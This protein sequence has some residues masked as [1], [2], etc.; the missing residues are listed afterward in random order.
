VQAL[1][2]GQQVTDVFTYTDSDNNGGSSTSTLT[3][4][5]TGSNDA[6]VAVA[7][8][9]A[10]KED[11]N[12]EAQ[13]NPVSGNLLTND[14][15]VDSGDTHA[16]SALSGGTDDGTT[17]TKVGTYGTLVIV[18]ATGAYTYTLANSQANVQALAAD[19]QVTDVFTYTNSDNHGGSSVSTLTVTVTGTNDAPV[20]VADVAALTEDA[21][22]NPVS[23]NLL[24][25]D[26]DVDTGDTH[27]VS[28]LS[29]GTDNGTTITKVGTYGTLVITKATGA[30]TY[31]LANSQANVQ[32]LAAGQQVTDV[33]TYTNP[34]N[35][36]GSSAS[37]L[38]LTVT[39]SND[40]PV[41]IADVAAVKEDTNTE[42]RPNPVTGN[43]LSNDID[44]DSN[45]T[46]TVSALS[47]GTDNGTTITKVGTYGTLVITKATGAYTYTLANSQANVQA[48]AAD[49][50][51]TDVFTYTNS[52]NH[53]GSSASTLTVTVTGTNDAPV[54][55]ADVASV[56]EDALS[57]TVTGNLL[58]N[59]TD[60][61]ST[62][63]HSVSALSGGT[64]NGTTITKVGT[65]GTLVITK[66]T[67]AYT[68]TLANGQANVQALA[69]GQQVTDVFTYTN[70]DNHGGSIAST[71]TLTVTGS[72]DAPV[73]VA[74]VAAVKEDTNTVARPN[75]VT[76]N[77]LSNDTD[78][79][80][81]DTHTVS[82]LSGGTDNGTTIT[83]VGTYGTLVITKATG[84]YTY[85]LANGQANV[86]ALADG[87]QVTDVF[88]YT[89]ADN[90]GGSGASTL[91]VTISGS[92]DA[93][94]AVADLAAVTEDALPNPV[95]GNLLANDTDVDSGDA[96]TVSA[97]SGG[98]DNGTT[99]TKVGTYGTLVI[100][101]A[102]G[103]YTYT[104]ANGQAN[105][106]A[107]ADGQQ[108][109]DVFT[110]TDSDN[111]GGSS[112]STL[113]VT[114]TGTA[115]ANHWS[116]ASSGLWGTASNW[117]NGAPT[118]NTNAVIDA[119]DDDF[120]VV[121][122]NT[123]AVANSLTINN[124]SAIVA[125]LSGGSLVLQ[126]A[127][128][129]SA[130]T[131]LLAGS[132][133]AN[134]VYVDDGIF[135]FLGGTLK[136]N[137]I[138]S[139]SHLYVEGSQNLL[140]ADAGIT[141]NGSIQVDFGSLNIASAVS[142]T[143]SFTITHE[144]TLDF[145]SSNTASVIFAEDSEGT[146]KI[147]Q[148]FDQSHSLTFGGL[149]YGVTDDTY[150]DVTN[151]TFVKNQMSWSSTYLSSTNTTTVVF[152]NGTG[153]QHFTLNLAGD[154]HSSSWNF[155]KDSAG[156]GTIFHDPPATDMAL[157]DLGA[158][159]ATLGVAT[160]AMTHTSAS[161]SADV[162]QTVSDALTILDQFAFQDDSQSNTQAQASATDTAALD[163]SAN[164]SSDDQSTAATADGSAD[165]SPAN[166]VAT[167]SQPATDN[168]TTSNTHLDTPTQTAASPAATGDTFVFAANFGNVTLTNFDPGTDVIEIDHTVFA[169][170]QALLAAAQDDGNGNSV[171]AADPH[172]TITIKN[173][174]VAQLIQHQGDFHF[175]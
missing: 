90:H 117:S 138:S 14:T 175:T 5:V 35:H 131:F 102:T 19:Q 124:P 130:G 108:V 40:A 48:L 39:G 114:V 151:F 68:Y 98:T 34:D 115:E 50:Q 66:A 9:T 143:G 144:A 92:N 46:H 71:L 122:I 82:A 172:D 11:T 31:T 157:A 167:N 21:Q 118:S 24:S 135:A 134:S 160:D 33:F 78:V 77:L 147:D 38:T 12:T 109:T 120:Y 63:T 51:V 126:G 54:A 170:F 149:V 95:S 103:A 136:T 152:G 75:P 10:V 27:S 105:V 153:G 76:G 141:N 3:V 88:T 81:T 121:G 84:A 42:A 37:T 79:D 69:A 26:T 162:A 59:D 148:A 119:D 74:D 163:T 1:A 104:L 156:T 17:L 159:A 6:P 145:D 72:N 2:D 53:G 4:T 166:N 112:A 61:D 99:I 80:S 91:T 20:A 44:V 36:G 87:Q 129:L 30:Y 174:T 60:V 67:G 43:L 168:S 85:T 16:V 97:L 116:T 137:S 173:V 132:L 110:Y 29:G 140:L 165:S 41:A 89:N 45:D 133:Q 96:H 139:G 13:P 23:G 146:L 106:Q 127:L 155:A 62:D 64:D 107:L 28:A 83:K 73:A 22:P 154:Y 18:K 150:F 94:V 101:K 169:D 7:D 49:Q 171:I 56:T 70:S 123:S 65:Y 52:D 164:S 55:V 111:H 113:T 100:T 25:N 86:Q 32:A 158:A 8:I 15:D 128:T 161:P 142:G 125:A 58:S 93:P 47:G 57:T